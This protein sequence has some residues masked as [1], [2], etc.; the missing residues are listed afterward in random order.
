MLKLGFAQII[1][2]KKNI[3]FL[4]IEL[5]SLR[6]YVFFVQNWW[7]FF[8]E[9]TKFLWVWLFQGLGKIIRAYI[10]LTICFY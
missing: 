3:L 8:E 4:E 5:T 7:A 10:V 1:Y 6:A 9:K 2:E